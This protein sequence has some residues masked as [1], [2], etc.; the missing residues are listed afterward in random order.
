[1]TGS[2]AE[3]AAGQ[4][5][6]LGGPSQSS[7]VGAELHLNLR[8]QGNGNQTIVIDNGYVLCH[9]QDMGRTVSGQLNTELGIG[10]IPSKSASAAR[11]APGVRY[12]GPDHLSRSSSI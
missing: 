6:G 1:M 8:I 2:V 4:T 11:T 12:V 9:A 7:G 10:L 3:D 5:T